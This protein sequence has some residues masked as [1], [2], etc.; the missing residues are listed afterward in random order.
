[1]RTAAI[2]AVMLLAACSRQD[3]V[4][5]DANAGANA[6]PVA[7][8]GTTNVEGGPPVTTSGAPERSDAAPQ[9]NAPAGTVP[10]LLHGRWGLTPEDCTSTRGDAKG[11]LVIAADSVRFYESR[12]VP[13]AD[14]TNAADSVSGEFRFTGEGKTWTKFMSLER[15]PQG[16]VRTERDPEV[17]FTYVRCN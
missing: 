11:L 17:S 9:A 14:V 13:T 2:I 6:L 1:M 10:P 3:P 16:L 15:R 12:A 7:N 8:E 4:A 5:D